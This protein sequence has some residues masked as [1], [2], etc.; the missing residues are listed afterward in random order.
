MFDFSL[1][2]YWNKDDEKKN[3]KKMNKLIYD[4]K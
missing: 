2:V 3:N 1:E 4:K